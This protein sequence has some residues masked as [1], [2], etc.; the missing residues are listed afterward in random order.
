MPGKL[1]LLDNLPKHMNVHTFGKVYE[2]L[3]ATTTSDFD[4]FE[5]KNI[6]GTNELSLH[7]VIVIGLRVDGA[8]VGGGEPTD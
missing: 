5:G 4:S 2:H 3:L 7:E 8:A 6:I 1:N